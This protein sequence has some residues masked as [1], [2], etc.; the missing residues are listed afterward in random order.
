MH[1][2]ASCCSPSLLA[3]LRRLFELR[4]RDLSQRPDA[5]LPCNG[6][7]MILRKITMSTFRILVP[8]K[9]AVSEVAS[10]RS[11]DAVRS[12]IEPG[13]T[14]T[15]SPIAAN[16]NGLAWPLLPFP[17]GWHTAA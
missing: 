3:S 2:A 5:I 8:S 6:V 13:Q 14:P 11:L 7:S 9:S 4:I 16:D 17:E 1:S 10:S 15:P 12:T